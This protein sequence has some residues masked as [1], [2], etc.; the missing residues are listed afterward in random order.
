MTDL[1][2][3]QLLLA[4]GL[5]LLAGLSTGIGSAMAF[6]A[7]RTST[8][9][10]S[11]SLGFSAGVMIYVSFVE[12]LSKAQASLASV[13]G[14]SGAAWAA[15]GGFFGGI[16]LIAIIDRLI[17]SYENP[18]EVR[19]IE[20]MTCEGGAA[21]PAPEK[22]MRMGVL[23]ALAIG[24]H[25]FPEGLATFT[26]ALADPAMGISIAIAIAIHNIPEGIAVSIPVFYAT[27]SRKRAF[28]MSFLSG[29]SEPVGAL[30]GF[31]LLQAFFT[32]AMFGY[33]F[34]GVGGIMVFISLDE[35]FPTAR[36]YGQGHLAIYGLVAGMGTMA[37]S[38]LLMR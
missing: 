2:K 3:D 13:Y 31:L 4:F 23:T 12:I 18:H 16:L 33:L 14:P 30:V 32:P 34:A 5:T 9:F 35:L 29:L 1:G 11:A 19:K 15:A 25:N 28:W 27:G 21:R 10:L 17:P 20:S 7:K 37:L 22:L 8:R 26:A 24:I 6:F 38:L 36:E